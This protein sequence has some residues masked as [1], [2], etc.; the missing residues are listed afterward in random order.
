[1]VFPSRWTLKIKND[2]IGRGMF[3]TILSAPSCLPRGPVLCLTLADNKYWR[4]IA[5]FGVE[6]VTELPRGLIELADSPNYLLAFLGFS[7]GGTSRNG[8]KYPEEKSEGT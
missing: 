3:S 5:S 2:G 8:K 6:V 7:S 4:E 1:M